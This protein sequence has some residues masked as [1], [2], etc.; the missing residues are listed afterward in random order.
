MEEKKSYTCYVNYEQ[1]TN[2]KKLSII[3]ECTILRKNQQEFDD[4]ADEM[5]KAINL[6]VTNN[7]N[8]MR[9]LSES[10]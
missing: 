6:A 2:F 7:T 3:Q 4:Y 8:H 5:Q 1:Y 9:M 10:I